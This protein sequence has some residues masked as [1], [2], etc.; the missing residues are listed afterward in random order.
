M[1]SFLIFFF[2]PG[3]AENKSS[4]VPH[5][6]QGGSKSH[7]DNAEQ[8]PVNCSIEKTG[9]L[10]WKELGTRGRTA[11][12]RLR[13]AAHLH[14]RSGLQASPAPLITLRFISGETGAQH[15]QS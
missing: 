9:V 2:F 11:V 5:F 4:P 14:A 6:I 8:V 15:S 12:K 10:W 13:P 1:T 3:K 7:D